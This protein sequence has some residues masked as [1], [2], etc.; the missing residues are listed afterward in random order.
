MKVF[1]LAIL[2]V[3]AAASASAVASL[4]GSDE[5]MKRDLKKIND[6][7]VDVDQAN[8]LDLDLDSNGG[9]GVDPPDVALCVQGCLNYLKDVACYSAPS[10]C[11][12]F[13]GLTGFDLAEC[14]TNFVMTDEAGVGDFCNNFVCNKGGPP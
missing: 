9:G 7:G 13:S 12:L 2:A 1:S 8:A 6:I 10:C 14:V 3:A 4:R 11:G 5:Q